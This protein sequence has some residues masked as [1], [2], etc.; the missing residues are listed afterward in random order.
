VPAVASLLDTHL[1][2]WAAFEPE[3]LSAKARKLL[4]S[5]ETPLAF[6]HATI[7]E[8]A[9]KTSLRRADF[10]VDPHQL[11]QGLLAEGFVELPIHASHIVRVASL[12]WV[13]RDPFDRLLV[14]QAMEEEMTLLTADKVL[15]G[16]GRFVRVV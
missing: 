7:W 3:R 13:H 9:I 16:Y 1:I 8:V 15:K 6:S 11:H 4:R 12:P 14:A 2:L 5:R 10:A